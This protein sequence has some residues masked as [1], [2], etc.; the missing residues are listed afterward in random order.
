MEEPDKVGRSGRHGQGVG[1]YRDLLHQEKPSQGDDEDQQEQRPE[2]A[3]L[4][5]FTVQLPEAK[6]QKKEVQNSKF[7]IQSSN[8]KIGSAELRFAPVQN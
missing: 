3:D 8:V 7:K 6:T 2:D 4:T 5:R 1:V